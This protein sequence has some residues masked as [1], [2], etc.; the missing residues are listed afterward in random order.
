MAS[1][2]LLVNNS[3][4]CTLLVNNISSSSADFLVPEILSYPIAVAAGTSVSLPIRFQPTG[5][6]PTPVGTAITVDSND[7]R[8]PQSIEVSGNA[9]AGKLAVTGSTFF[10]CVPGCCTEERT[11]SICNVGD[12][13]LRV[14]SVAFKRKSC[15]WRL[16]NNP[17][18]ATLH[19]GSCLAVVI[20]Y[21]ATQKFP[22]P[23]EIVIIS[24]DPTTPVKTLDVLATTVWNECGCKKCC[25]NCRK[26]SCEKR[27]C[28][29]CC[30]DK[31]H[32]DCDDE[33]D[34]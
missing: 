20:R 26:G 3:G 30:C 16:I 23:C 28:D 24:D 13:K 15:H 25:D 12:C 18:P 10:S 29:P 1:E 21:K 17:F 6:G 4:K 32:D 11:I 22:R 19:P 27:H 9:P 31:C 2:P 7:S 14:S 34:G 8:G 33:H 5:L